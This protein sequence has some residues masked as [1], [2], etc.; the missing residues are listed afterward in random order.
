MYA[1]D[2]QIQQTHGSS[3]AIW[4]NN[5]VTIFSSIC[6]QNLNAKNIGNFTTL[7]KPHKI[8]THLKGIETSFQVVPLYLKS[9]HVWVSSHFVIQNTKL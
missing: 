8:G 4:Q 6:H 2:P 9:F 7:L 3:A 1:E 5:G